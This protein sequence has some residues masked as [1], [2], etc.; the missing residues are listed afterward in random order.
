[1]YIANDGV[2]P[3]LLGMSRV[4]SEDA[5]RRALKHLGEREVTATAWMQRHIGNS[6]LG[7]LSADEWI[8]DVDATVKPLYGHQEGAVLGYNPHK[9]GRPSHVNHTYWASLR[10][11]GAECAEVLTAAPGQPC[12]DC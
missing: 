8:L 7:L 12:R 3:R 4:L 11:A 10:S 2:N 6:S 1:M 5:L 9:P